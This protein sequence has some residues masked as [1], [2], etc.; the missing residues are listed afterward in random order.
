MYNDHPCNLKI[1]V[2][3][4]RWS[5]LTGGRCWQ[6]VVVDRWSLFRG[7]FKQ[8]NKSKQKFQRDD[9]AFTCSSEVASIASSI[10]ASSSRCWKLHCRT[11]ES[12][13]SEY[14]DAFFCRLSKSGKKLL[15]RNYE[16]TDKLG[17]NNSTGPSIFVRYN[18]DIIITLK[19]YV[20]N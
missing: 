11:S 14:G 18:R 16:E 5:L 15:K 2:V 4:D 19:I 1:V 7:C 8:S 3:V 20:V 6:V 17:Y 9:A 12:F 13:R 10:L